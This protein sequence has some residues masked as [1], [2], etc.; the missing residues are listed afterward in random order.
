MRVNAKV[1]NHKPRSFWG[2]CGDL[3]NAIKDNRAPTD[4]MTE[5]LQLTAAKLGLR[6][7]VA[8][9]MQSMARLFGLSPQM[10]QKR[11]VQT[12]RLMRK[13]D[14]CK[15][16]GH[17]FTDR[18]GAKDREPHIAPQSC[19]NFSEYQEMARNIGSR[20]AIKNKLL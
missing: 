8:F 3:W 16:A 15:L 9:Q 13:C 11:E 14:G 5:Q 4:Q 6:N 19:P 7:R 20:T 10:L 12:L 2:S 17:C 18:R 1:H